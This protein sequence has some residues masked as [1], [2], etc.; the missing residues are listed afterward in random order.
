MGTRDHQ[1]L[2]DTQH[3]RTVV[4]NA[5]RSRIR[6]HEEGYRPGERIPT[7][8]KLMR[9]FDV[10]RAAV[11]QALDQ[12]KSEHLLDTDT[13]TQGAPPRVAQWES[14]Q[15]PGELR[16]AGVELADRINVAFQ[17]RH[18]ILDS[19]SLTTETLNGAVT[20][21]VTAMQNGE[22][23][24]PETITARLLVPTPGADLAL[25]RLVGDKSSTR[26]LKR[27][28]GLI[29][30]HARSLEHS[31][32]AMV[33]RDRVQRVVVEFRTIPMTPTHKLY[34]L[35]RSEALIGFYSVLPSTVM[36]RAGE[37][38][39]YDVMGIDTKLLRFSTL[40]STATEQDTAMIAESQ[41]WFDSLWDTIAEEYTPGDD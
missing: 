31:L 30:L 40:D 24:P 26:P 11:R 8:G 32:L 38:E 33:E 9:E 28:Y 29:D 3:P 16:P 41:R 35:N 20:H 17:S 5:L 37:M 36:D 2:D 4:A 6:A 22:L 12:L 39:I 25:P 23:D 19:Y 13:I 15:P 21:A 27:L 10:E 1:T 7:Q 14:A 18:V 34:L